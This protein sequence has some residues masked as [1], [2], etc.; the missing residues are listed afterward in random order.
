MNNR[1]I[2]ITGTDTGVGKTRVTV[3]LMQRLVET[4]AR[5]GGMKPV[6]SGCIHSGPALVSDDASLI[7]QYSNIPLQYDEV[8]PIAM[9]LPVSPDI[10]A[11]MEGK[12]IGLGPVKSVYARLR[13][14]CDYLLVEGIGGWRT[15]CTS[16]RGMADIV[17]E[18]GIPVILVVGL[19]LGCINHALLTVEAIQ[20]DGFQLLGW[21]AN[22][23]DPDFGY[24]EQTLACL[25]DRISVPLL[26]DL[27]YQET[28]DTSLHGA[29]LDINVICQDNCFTRVN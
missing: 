13:Q 7:L 6:A 22:R 16:S 15:P 14:R 9:E 4:G 24:S 5:V 26:G 19:R 29:F 2:F 25:A 17:E 28:P 23:I 10:A 8:N 21:V 11:A 12:D 27:P 20:K 1:S 3:A 18:L